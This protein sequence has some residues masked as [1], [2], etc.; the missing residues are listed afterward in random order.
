MSKCDLG[1]R[2]FKGQYPKNVDEF[3]QLV[4]LTTYEDYADIL[5]L[6]QEDKLPAPPVV[7]LQTTWESGNK[8]E[9]WAPYSEDMLKIYR[10]NIIAAMLLST[11]NEKGQFHVQSGFRA[12]YALAP[13]PYATGLFPDLILPALLDQLVAVF[14]GAAALPHNGVVHRLAGVAVPYDGGFPLVGDADA[15]N[16]SC[17]QAKIGHSL[18]GHFQLCGENFVCIVFYPAGLREDLCEFLLRH[19]AHLSVFVK[20]DAAV[21]GGTR[22]QGHHIAFQKHSPFDAGVLFGSL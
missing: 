15:C 6:R 22:I 9:K 18:P 12:L 2:F 17:G 10:T 8:P 13:M 3:R 16:V 19:R 14:S 4:P 5:L 20:Q 21:A 7:W 11:S 1:Q